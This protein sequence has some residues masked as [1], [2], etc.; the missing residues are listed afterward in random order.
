MQVQANL[1]INVG[2]RRIVISILAK[3]TLTKINNVLQLKLT[4][5]LNL[6]QPG[7]V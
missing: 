4:I 7:N 1:D 3:T 2:Y 6:L 5:E